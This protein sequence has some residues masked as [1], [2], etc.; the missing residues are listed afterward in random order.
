MDSHN[1]KIMTSI[2]V[3]IITNIL[4]QITYNNINT[5]FNQIIIPNTNILSIMINI[6]S[7]INI[8]KI[9]IKLIINQNY[10]IKKINNPNN[11]YH[12]SLANII[13]AIYLLSTHSN[14]TVSHN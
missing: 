8:N 4:I 7:Y 13:V 11:H 10:R 6:N 2:T 3:K 1:N 12:H 5:I 9:H 14:R